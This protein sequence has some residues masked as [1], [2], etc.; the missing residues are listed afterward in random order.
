V[1]NEPLAAPIREWVTEWVSRGRADGGVLPDL[2]AA[3]IM[4]QFVAMASCF[5]LIGQ[6]LSVER[7]EKTVVR[8]LRGFAK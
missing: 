6:P 8:L 3:A 1:L 7:L 5:A 2:D 4:H